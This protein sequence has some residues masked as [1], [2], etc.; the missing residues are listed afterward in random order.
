MDCKTNN[1][2]PIIKK[3]DLISGRILPISTNMVGELV[4]GP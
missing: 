2:D 1:N 3:A 4:N